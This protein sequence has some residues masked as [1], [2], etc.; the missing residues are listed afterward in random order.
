M[1]EFDILTWQLRDKIRQDTGSGCWLWTAY[2]CKKAGYGYV[3]MPSTLAPIQAYRAV[4]VQL[5]GPI[6][7]TLQL[8]HLCRVRACV[9]PEHLEVVTQQENSKRGGMARKLARGTCA[10]GR[11]PYTEENPPEA[12]RCKVCKAEDD[13]N[14]KKKRQMS[15]RGEDYL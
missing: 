4:W 9:N 12:V 3:R 14:Y 15:R 2:T 11:H 5:R 8:D 10:S 7:E 1:A 13:R 6:P